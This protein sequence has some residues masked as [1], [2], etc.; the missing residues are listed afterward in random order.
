MKKLVFLNSRALLIYRSR[1]T[2][3]LL[4]IQI[5][6]RTRGATA[7]G[8]VKVAD[9]KLNSK[10]GLCYSNYGDSVGLTDLDFVLLHFVGKETTFWINEEFAHE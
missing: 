4:P 9:F 1:V 10:A 2:V 7:A 8:S 6:V 3:C 5:K